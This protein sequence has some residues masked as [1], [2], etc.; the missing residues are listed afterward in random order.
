VVTDCAVWLPKFTKEKGS[1][2]SHFQ[3]KSTSRSGKFLLCLMC[4][5]HQR[6]KR[7]ASL[8]RSE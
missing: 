2:L 4:L 5:L 8:W 3:G 7:W 6:L 1:K